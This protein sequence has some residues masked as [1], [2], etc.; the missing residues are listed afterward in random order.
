M[1]A[2][3]I[4]A[5]FLNGSYHG[6]EWPASPARLLQ[7]MVA[8]VKTGRHRELWPVVQPALEWLERQPAPRILA[9]EPRVGP[10]YRLAVPNNDMDVVAHEW[11][12][13]RPANPADLRTMKT[14]R[15]YWV[16]EAPAPHLRYVWE[17][18]GD[19]TGVQDLVRRLKALTHCLHTLGWGI[20]M[21][22]ADVQLLDE[23]QRT[24]VTRWVPTE[25]G[26]LD[27]ATPIPGF[28]ADLEQTYQR[29]RRRTS[30]AGAD[31]DARP[32]MF[33]MQR[34]S[35]EGTWHRPLTAFALEPAGGT[36][37]YSRDWHSTIVVAGQM[38][39]AA[40]G[41]L[42]REGFGE[43]FV[44]S[45]I[46]GHGGGDEP[47]RMSFVP[48]ASIGHAHSDGRIRRA[49]FVEPLNG[50]GEA[51][52]MLAAALTGQA[53]LDEQTGRPA[54]QFGELERRD[55]VT[56]VYVERAKVWRSVTP[57]VL[58]GFNSNSGKI[59]LKKTDR[60]LYRAFEMA[61]YGRDLIENIVFQAAPLWGGTGAAFHIRL[62]KH[63]ERLPRYHVE[64]RFGREVNGPV[65]AGIGRHCGLGVFAAV[66]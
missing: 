24:D 45:F 10:A 19:E 1:R 11:A 42:R 60:L 43:D 32:T 62:P 20:D 59:S 3:S 47:V 53:A 44:T 17:V 21:S 61:G 56:R 37:P 30:G 14:V 22:Y 4:S 2:V 29:F 5:T 51:V 38:R 12:A 27:L 7:G 13:G 26:E 28:T 52:R 9:V 55:T 39:H 64:V 57:V 23:E 41:V 25:R 31:A 46:E 15:P 6:G 50:D 49:M 33:R 35:V 16:D 63:L 48:L 34:Y 65:L 66:R 40:A 58:H 36:R 54:F 8:G 18:T